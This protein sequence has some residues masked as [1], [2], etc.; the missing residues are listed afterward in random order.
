MAQMLSL[1]IYTPIE[2]A[3]RLGERTTQLRLL[4][5]WKR[6]TLAKRSGVSVASI[7]RFETSGH[8]SL[9]NLLKVALALGCL[10][11]FERLM[12]PPAPGSIAELDRQ[13]ATPPR[14][15]GTR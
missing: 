14:R 5:N 4:Q 15:R 8:I 6:D 3:R 9:D 10:V 13:S 7:K 2:L 11:Q 12:E 1:G